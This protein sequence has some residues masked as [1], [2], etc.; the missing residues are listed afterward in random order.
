MLGGYS[1]V[2]PLGTGRSMPSIQMIGLDNH[3]KEHKLLI[4]ETNKRLSY[5]SSRLASAVTLAT[6]E[7]ILTG[8]LGMEREVFLL[9]WP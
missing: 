2:A 9:K 6:G 7:V 5:S 8:G 3:V 1:P 4:P